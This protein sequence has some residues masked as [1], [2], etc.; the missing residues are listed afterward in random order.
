MKY[1]PVNPSDINFYQGLYGIRKQGQSI[2]G[3]E[4]SGVIIEAYNKELIGKNVSILSNSTNGTFATHAVT[5][6]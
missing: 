5:I 6:L 4:G 3:F 2:V 1:A